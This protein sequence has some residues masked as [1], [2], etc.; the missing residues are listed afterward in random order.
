MTPYDRLIT[1]LDVKQPDDRVPVTPFNREWCARQAGYKFSEVMVNTEKYVYSQLYCAKKFGYDMVLDL[2]AVHAESEAMGSILKIPEDAPPFVEKPAVQDYK[3]DFPKL[4]IPNPSKDGR[5]PIILRGIERMKEACM[6]H[7]PVMGY[8]Q[9]CWRHTCMLRGTENAMRDIRKNPDELKKLID[10]ATE[11]L[12]VYGEAVAEAGAD[13]IWVSD[14]TSSGDMLSR[15]HFEDFILPYLKRQ[16]KVLLKT[17]VKVFLHICG[18]VNDRLDLMVSTGV[19]AISVDEKVNLAHAK[20][21][22]GKQVCIMGNISPSKTLLSGT[23]SDVENEAKIA[24]DK[25]AAGGGF[26]LASGCITPISMPPE[27]VESLVRTAKTY[28]R[29]KK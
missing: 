14:P 19:N 12:I 15:K 21:L 16:I 20:E 3:Q 2:L 13:L 8:V 1:A 29:Y 28:G 11:S 9:A 4:K 23:V 27:N 26:V 7:M 24:I 5:L 25:A 6:G 18:N 10:I 17:G 22:I